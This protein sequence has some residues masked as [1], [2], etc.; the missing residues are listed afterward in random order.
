MPPSITAQFFIN[1]LIALKSQYERSLTN[2]DTK[3]ILLREQLSHV[4]ALLLNQLV[5]T[6]AHI[7]SAEPALILEEADT[8]VE[9]LTLSPAATEAPV[10]DTPKPKASTRKAKAALEP[11]LASGKRSPRPLLPAYVGLKRLEAIAQ[12]LQSTPEQ[13]VTAAQVGEGLFGNLSAADH[14]AERKRLN[15]LLY[16]G[17]KRKLWQKGTAPASYR[18]GASKTDENIQ[19]TAAKSQPQAKANVKTEKAIALEPRLTL[20]LLP[21]H[22]G[23]NKLEAIQKVLIEQSGHVLHQDTIFQLLYGDVSPDVLKVERLRIRASLVQGVTKGLWEKAPQPSSYWVSVSSGR[24]SKAG[25]VP[26]ESSIEVPA[27]SPRKPGR[28]PKAAAASKARSSQKP[29]TPKQKQ[30]ELVKL[31][32]KANIQI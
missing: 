13:D 9:R 32:R 22:K 11:T 30:A 6:K 31:I 24:K 26:V 10:S 27:A 12:L 4:N 15:T 25:A 17:E 20:G 5:P 1:S 16:Q 14:K 2:A 7:K 28:K 23:L 19:R 29:A 8:Q 3:A 18:I 21:V